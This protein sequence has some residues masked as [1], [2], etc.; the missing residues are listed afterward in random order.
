[1]PRNHASGPATF[2]NRNR[3]TNKT[4]LRV[5][6]GPVEG[7]PLAFDEDEEK[8]RVVSTAGVDAEDANEHHLQ[9]VLTASSVRHQQNVQRST[10]GAAAE[11]SEKQP[12]AFIPIPDNAGVVDD[13]DALYPP[14]RWVEPSTYVKTSTTIEESVSGALNDGFTYYMDERDKEWLDR[15]NEESRGE[16]TSAQGAVSSSSSAG[17]RTS[18][19]AKAKGKEPDVSQAVA[20]SEDEFELVMGIFEKVTHEK[21]PFLHHVKDPAN[22]PSFSDYQD[23]FSNPLPPATFAVFVVP[24]W[25][26]QPAQLLRYAKTVYSYWRERRIERN[27]QRIIPVLNYDES[28]L[29]NESYICFRRRDVKAMRKTRASQ[30]SS[31][32]KL[33]RLQ[34]ELESAHELARNLCQREALKREILQ[35]SQ[36]VWEGRE[37]MVSLK[38]KFPGLGVKED[39]ELLVDKERPPKKL[40]Q[41]E[42]RSRISLKLPKDIPAATNGAD[43]LVMRPKDRQAMIQR[44]IDA[45]IAKQKAK[46]VSWEDAIDNAYQPAPTTSGQRAF[47][48]IME[49]PVPV[50]DTPMPSYRATRSR[51]GRGGIIRFDR[52][53]HRIKPLEDQDFMALPRE[54][55]QELTIDFEADERAER[56]KR[57]RGQWMFDTDDEPALGPDGQ[58]EQDRVLVNDFDATHMR[59]TMTLLK[60]EDNE[61]M[62]TNPTI[63]WKLV[64]GTERSEVPFRIGV[65][66]QMRRDQQQAALQIQAQRRAQ[67]QQAQQAAAQP[68]VNGTVQ[69][70]NG[71]PIAHPQ[72]IPPTITVQTPIRRSSSSVGAP[73]QRI[74]S[75]STN[76]V[77]RPPATPS[78]SATLSTQASPPR[79]S[80]SPAINGDHS[81]R[82][83]SALAASQDIV[84]TPAPVALSD[85]SS[86]PKPTANHLAITMPSNG[87]HMTG[88]NGY[89]AASVHAQ[90]AANANLQSLHAHMTANNLNV[91]GVGVGVNS[92]PAAY[93]G[94]VN[95][96]ASGYT[97]P[98]MGSSNMN[99]KLPAS[100]QMQWAASQHMPGQGV[101]VGMGG[102]M[103]VGLGVSIARSA[104][105]GSPP[106]PSQSP[107]LQHQAVVN[108][109]QGY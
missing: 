45:E 21:T 50:Q 86:P 74:S 47:K 56:A 61:A 67:Q 34:Q 76:G 10:R 7:D 109:T 97:V 57:L 43:E 55:P 80:A 98:S 99:L 92:R 39:D 81:P 87:Y 48:F 69:Q 30:A 40:R 54:Q 41:S 65:T 58:D 44:T 14:N 70:P 64:D 71:I 22:Y 33:R 93:M 104:S 25:V 32:E 31:S 85:A 73:M 88:V 96:P 15:N 90:Q 94:H 60:E 84:M 77:M 46:D 53:S 2:R 75:T 13:Y 24:S 62:Q 79:T 37:T 59:K 108:G 89:G 4:R 82:P 68:Q 19:S 35:C 1:M 66:L 18:R 102:G 11:K 83:P 78:A 42:S 16:G 36:A 106:R 52:R 12:E 49:E 29:K 107:S 8:A 27:G 20:M 38:R 9:A 101:G 91:P 5:I 103:G 23:T 3:V 63:T 72:A 105:A 95:V 6:K 17:P 28:D 51:R 26:P 100:R